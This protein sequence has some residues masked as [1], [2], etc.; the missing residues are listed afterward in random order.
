MNERFSGIPIDSGDKP[1]RDEEKKITRRDFLKGIVATALVGGVTGQFIDV[2]KDNPQN[3]QNSATLKEEGVEK[4]TKNPSEEKVEAP[5]KS[6]EK[7]PTVLTPL[8]QL[9]A[10]GEV[11]DLG[12]GLKVIHDEHYHKLAETEDGKKD[13]QTAIENLSRYDMK[14]LVAP[15]KKLGLPEELAY[16]VAIQENRGR[17]TRSKAGARGMTGILPQTALGL[18]YLPKKADNPYTASEITAKYFAT[19]REERFGDDIDMLLHAYSAGGYLYGFTEKVPRSERTPENF[20]LYM[21]NYINK[22]FE[23]V[24]AKGYRYQHTVEDEKNLGEVS[25]RFDVPIESILKAN[26]LTKKS[27]LKKGKVLVIPFETKEKAIQTVFRKPMEALRYAP[28][29]RAKYKAL[30]SLGLLT[31]LDPVFKTRKSA[32]G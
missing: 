6:E 20:Y 28:E 31:K 27:I 10:Y 11:R 5:K 12:G 21:A 25:R 2:E 30:K 26:N 23:E 14:A 9:V 4:I 19:E 15:F 17:I 32:L 1:N 3:T 22:K 13:M 8:E 7:I 16:M 29:V 24:R 18:G